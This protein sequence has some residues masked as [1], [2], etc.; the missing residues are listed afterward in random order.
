MGTVVSHADV[1][2]AVLARDRRR[3]DKSRA[4]LKSCCKRWC[5]S[6]GLTLDDAAELSLG[7]PFNE[8]MRL[9]Q[10]ALQKASPD[11]LNAG[12]N[13]RSAAKSMRAAYQALLAS[14]GLP[15]NFNEA[16][17]MA[18]DA[19][20]MK[21]ADLNRAL[22]DR[23]YGK[24]NP[25]W[26]GAQL[27]AFYDGTAR[28]GTSW[29]GDSRQMLSRCEEILG[30]EGG[31]L[32]SRAYP[33]ATP[34]LVG[35]PTSIPYRVARSEQWYAK[36]ALAKLP[37]RLQRIWCQVV[38]WRHRDSHLVDGKILVVE[39]M[40]IW[41]GSS[42]EKHY[43][44]VLRYFGWLCL[45]QADRPLNEVPKEQRWMTGQGMKVADLRMGQLLDVNP[46]LSELVQALKVSYKQST[47]VRYWTNAD[48]GMRVE[49]L[50]FF[51]IKMINNT[52]TIDEIL[53]SRVLTIPT[54]AKPKGIS[55]SSEGRLDPEQRA[56]L[57]D[58]LHTCMFSHV[59]DIARAYAQIFPSPTT[60]EDEISAPLRVIAHLSGDTALQTDLERA[61][62]AG[63]QPFASTP[64]ELMEEAVQHILVKSIKDQ[65]T[66]R[67][68]L[69]VLEVLMR[70]RL[71]ADPKFGKSSTTEISDVESPEWVGRQFRQLYAATE[72]TVQRT[73][74]YEVGIRF[75]AL[76]P[77]VLDRAVAAS[78]VER[79]RLTEDANPRLFCGTCSTCD[80]SGSCLLE[81]R[82]PASLG[83]TPRDP[84][85]RRPPPNVGASFH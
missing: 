27:W 8:K 31:A 52:S 73:T 36:Y 55:L 44:A 34:I 80:Y 74:M 14:Q 60:R 72:A 4:S 20:Q 42:A 33:T 5:L 76:H 77:E 9:Y 79:S 61:L 19:K 3:T 26:Y 50:K 32:L 58:Q 83:G 13:V 11:K 21:P 2:Q 37:S 1:V 82:K 22:F 85:K 16:F 28:P 15:V 63:R 78:G 17:R 71:L 24:E 64:Q 40:S 30:L 65:Q 49:R 7:E 67:T 12:K 70:L 54:R 38:D 48:G 35:A 53:E 47:A 10:A 51:G 29:R 41:R 84:S 25:S 56:Q 81:R 45:P 66:L 43:H 6:H 23:Y 75:W 68:T 57:R 69:T 39:G 46:N 62:G 18:M 59:A